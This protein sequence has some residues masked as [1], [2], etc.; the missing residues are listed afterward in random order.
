MAGHIWM[1]SGLTVA[2]ATVMGFGL[3]SYA[4]SPQQTRTVDV[5]SALSAQDEMA[6]AGADP[7]MLDDGPTVPIRCSGCGPS[8]AD[9][10]F[11]ADRAAYDR[12]SV[13]GAMSDPVV[14]DYL[15]QGDTMPEAPPAPPPVQRLPANIV[16][17]AA[18]DAPPPV[19]P[20]AF[21]PE[22]GGPI[23]PATPVAQGDLP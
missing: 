9:R 14:Q 19:V 20:T 18:G 3:G 5:D 11:A 1:M 7:A 4:V 17:F 10:R 15:A 23:A 8:L 2:A 6:Q 13:D 22:T 16:R 21:T 12:Y